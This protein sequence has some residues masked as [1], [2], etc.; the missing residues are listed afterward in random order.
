MARPKGVTEV[1]FTQEDQ[2]FLQSFNSREA[3][4]GGL[5]NPLHLAAVI[6]PVCLLM[7]VDLTKKGF[8]RQTL[9]EVTIYNLWIWVY[10]NTEAQMSIALGNNKP[11]A[12]LEVEKIL[13]WAL[14]AISEGSQLPEAV[15]EQVLTQIPWEKLTSDSAQWN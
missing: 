3:G 1:Q 13:W 5:R 12:L 6:S 7:T 9:I 15:V 11:E 2:E 8:H 10:S 14:F 4:L